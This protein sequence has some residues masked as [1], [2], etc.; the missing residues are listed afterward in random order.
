MLGFNGLDRS[1]VMNEIPARLIGYARVSTSG[2]SYEAQAEALAAFGCSITFCDIASGARDSRPRLNEMIR[3]LRPGDVVVVTRTD[4]LARS[5]LG[6]FDIIRRITEAGAQFRSIAEPVIDTSSSM[7][8]VVLAVIGALGDVERDLIKVRTAEG[9][10]RARARGVK[11]GRP[12]KLTPL[13]QREVIE[14]LSSRE[15]VADIA[16]SFAVGSATIYRI[17]RRDR[18]ATA[19]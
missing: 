11:L 1:L 19:S 12:V 4:R 2:Q 5:V 17:A 16:R 13:Q 18:L 6:L 3:R 10:A 14:R 15:P 9:R 7:G 8:R